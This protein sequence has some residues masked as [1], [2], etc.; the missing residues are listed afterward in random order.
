M[1]LSEDVSRGMEI[2]QTIKSSSSF[3]IELSSSSPQHNYD[4]AKALAMKIGAEWLHRGS[5]R[6]ALAK[7]FSTWALMIAIFCTTW[8][9]LSKSHF[10]FGLL[11]WLILHIRPL[12]CGIEIFSYNTN[13]LA[14]TQF[15]ISLYGITASNIA[16]YID[17]AV[18]APNHTKDTSHRALHSEWIDRDMRG[19]VLRMLP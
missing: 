13:G 17:W 14:R 3:H 7:Q 8:S 18:L 11:L 15:T 6:C 19:Q 16:I 4:R 10:L 1:W 12:H 2:W 9:G 5:D